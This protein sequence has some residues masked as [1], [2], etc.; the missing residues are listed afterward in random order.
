MNDTNAC[1]QATDGSRPRIVEVTPDTY[2]L[3]AQHLRLT[4]GERLTV[5]IDALLGAEQVLRERAG[6]LAQIAEVEGRNKWQGERI[7]D[8]V[9]SVLAKQDTISDLEAKLGKK[10]RVKK[11]QIRKGPKS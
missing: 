1:S 9:K 11:I 5:V 2:Y 10:S 6:L 3:L 8:L 7:A 4:E